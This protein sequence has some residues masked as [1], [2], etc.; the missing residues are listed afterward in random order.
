MNERMSSSAVLAKPKVEVKP[1]INQNEQKID[2]SATILDKKSSGLLK[3]RIADKLR[4]MGEKPE[5]ILLLEIKALTSKMEELMN[6]ENGQSAEIDA[7]YNIALEERMDKQKQLAQLRAKNK[8][9]KTQNPVAEPIQVK[10]NDELTSKLVLTPDPEMMEKIAEI[11]GRTEGGK[12]YVETENLYEL[13]PMR[14]LNEN[15]TSMDIYETAEKQIKLSVKIIAE[16][17]N[18]LKLFTAQR[19]GKSV[20][21]VEQIDEAMKRIE[22]KIRSQEEAKI[23]N[24]G[25]REKHR[26]KTE[27]LASG[28]RSTLVSRSL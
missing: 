14:G 27:N 17:E 19:N 18:Q 8:E 24:I 25:L 15:L 26:P 2:S 1:N 28:S 5:T 11:E 6:T 21:D 9:E 12:P 23:R 10:E 3:D 7:Q 13:P 4:E 16:L 22:V 20:E